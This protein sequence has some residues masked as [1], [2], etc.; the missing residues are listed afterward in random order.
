MQ[1]PLNEL[2]KDQNIKLLIR[3]LMSA[4]L[5]CPYPSLVVVGCLLLE[6]SLPLPHPGVE[7]DPTHNTGKGATI[8]ADPHA[9]LLSPP[10]QFIHTYI[11]I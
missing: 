10:F 3:L 1:G 4:T 7:Q 8:M 6:A 11:Y 2:I 9:I 5:C